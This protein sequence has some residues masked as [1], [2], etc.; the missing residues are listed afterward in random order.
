MVWE[1]GPLKYIKEARSLGGITL[2]YSHMKI[3]QIERYD[4]KVVGD[5]HTR[6]WENGGSLKS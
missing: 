4:G 6:E 1:A 5:I 3:L 2:P